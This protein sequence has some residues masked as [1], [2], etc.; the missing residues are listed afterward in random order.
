MA[1][2]RS[3][4]KGYVLDPTWITI[5]S[6]QTDYHFLS[7]ETYLINGYINLYGSIHFD[8]GCYIKYAPNAEITLYGASANCLGTLDNPTVLTSEDDDL[9]GLQ[10]DGSTGQPSYTASVALSLYWV[11]SPTTVS[12][13]KIRWASTAVAAVN[14]ACSANTCTLADS[15]IELC[16]VGVS[17][18]N[19]TFNIQNSTVC[20]V[21]TPMHYRYCGRGLFTDRCQG[22][23]DPHITASFPS[24]E[25]TEAGGAY[26]PDTMGAVGPDHFLTVLNSST[27]GG[28]VAVYDKHTCQRLTPVTATPQFLQVTVPSGQYAGTYAAFGDPEVIYDQG[29]HRWIASAEDQT[30]R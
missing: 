2:N 29:S 16:G 17:A 10:I 3:R 28:G 18:N 8:A 14:S 12:G 6:D 5:D 21:P 23:T 25:Q 1:S 15:S 11:P 27:S 4:P 7:G 22:N 20:N 9:Y 13:F 19:C 26:P 30:Y 24:I